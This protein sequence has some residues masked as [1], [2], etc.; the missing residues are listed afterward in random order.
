MLQKNFALL[1]VEPFR[2]LLALWMK[3]TNVKPSV[4]V[5]TAAVVSEMQKALKRP[6]SNSPVTSICE[7]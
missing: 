1:P 5:F 6:C 4:V 7:K 2:M 3:L